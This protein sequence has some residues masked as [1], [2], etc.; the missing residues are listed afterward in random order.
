MHS[1]EVK[2]ISIKEFREQGYL[3]EINRRFLHPLGLALEIIID[4]KTQEMRLGGVWDS[5]DDPEG[6]LYDELDDEDRQRA[7]NIRRI[8]NER[9][10]AREQAL[11]YWIQ[12]LN[13][14]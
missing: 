3:L 11:G 6:F 14:A 5:R 10:P 9:R 1:D 2:R 12:P 7:E 4:D 8:E 13:H